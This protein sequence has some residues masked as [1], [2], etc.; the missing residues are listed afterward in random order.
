MASQALVDVK[1]ES[2]ERSRVAVHTQS[3]GGRIASAALETRHG[4]AG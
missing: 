1:S 2:V 3:L 4:K